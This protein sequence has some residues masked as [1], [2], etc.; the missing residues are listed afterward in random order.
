MDLM[1]SQRNNP[2]CDLLKIS[3]AKVRI[4]SEPT[5]FFIFLHKENIFSPCPTIWDNRALSLPAH[6][7]LKNY[8]N[9]KL[10]VNYEKD[11]RT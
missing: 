3:A 4:F 8:T 2:Y 1:F 5:N 6:I 7:Y 10:L 11:Y 9:S